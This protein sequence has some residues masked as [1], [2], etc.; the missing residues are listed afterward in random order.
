MRNQKG[1]SLLEVLV[2]LALIGVLTTGFL[3]AMSN[4]TKGAIM[5]DRID[6][7]RALAQGQMEYVKKLAFSTNATVYPPDPNM[8][9]GSNQ[10]IN[11]PGYSVAISAS[12]AAQRSASIQTI[13]VTIFY[14]NTA[15]ATLQD[16]KAQ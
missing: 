4:A 15:A 1:F 10:F 7:S 14:N 9:N 8:V 16:C 5:N 13:T 12:N 2:S 6:T 11:Y 3:G